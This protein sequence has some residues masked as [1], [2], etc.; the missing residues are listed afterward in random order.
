MLKKCLLGLQLLFIASFAIGAEINVREQQGGLFF[1][2]VSGPIERQDAEKFFEKTSHINRAVVLLNSPGGQVLEALAIGRAIRSKGFATAVPDQT[3]CVSACALIWLAGTQR[4]AED[5]SVVGFHAA[6][7]VK[8]GQQRETGVGNALIGAYLNELGFSQQAVVFVT[9]APPEGIE[10]LDRIK[11]QRIG[12][13][14]SSVSRG[15]ASAP[16]S[17][18]E[19]GFGQQPYDPVGTVQRFYAALANADGNSASALVVPEKRGIGPFNEK[20]ITQFFGSMKE[21]LTVLSIEQLGNDSIRVSYRYRHSSKPC[22]GTALVS[23][24]YLMGNTLIRSIQA[25][26]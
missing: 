11:G 18:Q 21:P 25:N 2:L 22:A 13:G 9:S 17:R 24:Q 3:L 15:A 23:T 5:S 8:N 20:N 6:Y 7:V 12:I 16:P 26:C 14:F 19:S 4:F 10:R 1:V